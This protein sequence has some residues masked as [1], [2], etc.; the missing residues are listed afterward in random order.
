[1]LIIL[2]P[3]RFL[4]SN[5][6]EL[7]QM[8]KL[9]TQE[10]IQNLR[11]SGKILV[12]VMDALV[13]NSQEGT[14]LKSLDEH[15][16]M[17]INKAGAKPAFLDYQPEGSR[18]PYPAAI[19]ASVN[20]QI[21]HGVPSS[22]TLKQGDVFKID[23][24]IN[25]NGFFTDAAVTVGIGQIS[26]EA[27]K[28]MQVTRNSL[29]EA[30]K[31]CKVGKRLGDIGAVIEAT[32]KKANFHIV[33]GLTGHGVGFGVHEEPVIHNF[34]KSGEGLAL[35]VGMVLAI[36]PMISLGTGEIKQSQDDSYVTADNT[37]AAH[38]EKTIAIT[39]TGPEVLTDL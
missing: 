12:S 35:E 22:Y 17:L 34:G 23:L 10:D 31:V 38:F 33:K 32:A 28:L 9:K 21:V 8:I 6:L 39:S 14:S 11:I 24:G 13:R 27:E 25:Y 20:E 30:I 7:W 18:Y 36:E 19:C 3:I 26:K 1:M 15:A 16:R 29:K 5:G 37:L 4:L 2:D